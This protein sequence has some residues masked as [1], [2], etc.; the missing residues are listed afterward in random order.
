MSSTSLPI[1]SFIGTGV[2]G[3]SMAGHLLDAGYP[4]IVFNRTKTR[5]DGLLAAGAR[6]AESAG[7]AAAQADVVITIVGYPADVES[8]YLDPDGIVAQAREGALLID[9]TTS[10][11]SLAVRIA[12]A[13]QDRGLEA[14]DAPVSGGDVGAREGTLTIMAGGSDAAFGRAVP[15]FE[16]MGRAWTHVGGPGAGQHTKMANQIAIAGTML[17]MVEAFSYAS[18]AGLDA[19]TTLRAIGA[20]GAG[21]WSM[22]N[23]V[24]RIIN[25]DFAPGFFVKHFIK[26]LGI[27]I[28]EARQMGIVLPG[29]ELAERLY[30]R[31][32]EEDGGAELGTQALWMLYERGLLTR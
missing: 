11:P 31:L 14:I 4:L 30:R 1:V 16:C 29:L 10:T 24:P 19:Q 21:S 7:E 27:A 15:L 9:M 18:A 13:A 32:A 12:Q 20:G 22:A 23:Y 2:M 25:G 17:G 8:V 6:W 28:G 26:D 5:A 3:A